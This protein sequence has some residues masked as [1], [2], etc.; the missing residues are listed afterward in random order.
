VVT[1]L[2]PDAPFPARLGAAAAAHNA[3]P[4]LQLNPS[5]SMA[6]V[7]AGQD[8]AYLSRLAAQIRAYGHQVIMSW[9]PEANGNW[10]QWGAPQ[11]PPEQYRAAWQHVMGVF[12]GVHNV[13]WMVTINRT[14]A[15]AAPTSDYIIPGV[16]MYGID[17]YYSFPDDTFQSVFGQTIAQIRAETTKPIL[18]S[19]TG[20]G[21]AA[22]QVRN[23]PGL[24]AGVRAQHLA[25]L[26]YF[27]ENQGTMSSYHQDWA[28]TPAA[29]T[30]LRAA[31]RTGP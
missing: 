9:A 16:D 25:G 26:V 18:I 10:S 17:A 27:N 28:L 22:V 8:D 11:T 7:T 23:I 31:L 15:T 19:E 1:Y 13:T 14:Y 12:H 4:I 5:M 20:I 24:V 2:G 30:V 6:E 3:E 21:Q 29:L